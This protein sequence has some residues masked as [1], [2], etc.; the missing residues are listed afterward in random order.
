VKLK[1]N[2]KRNTAFLYETL[3]RELTKTTIQKNEQKK[4]RLLVLIKEHFDRSTLLGKELELYKDLSAGEEI[5][6]YTA[7]K[8]IFEVRRKHAGLDKKQLF[9]EQTTLIDKMNKMFS[10]SIFSN[11]VPNYKNLATINQIFDDNM[12]I[13][14]RV[15]LEENLIS[16]LSKEK[17]TEEKELKPIDNLTYKTFVENYNKEYSET[18]LAEQKELLCKYVSS[19]ADNGLELKMYLNEELGRLKNTIHESLEMNEIKTDPDMNKNTKEVLKLMEN[20][21]DHTIDG[22]M[23]KKVL[24]VQNLVKELETKDNDN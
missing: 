18:L 2:K 14:K 23:V 19:F 11:F 20:F 5:A 13:K 9:K 8:L 21:K 6:P 22:E 1:H 3:I 24:Q 12:S 4:G 17:E 16:K 10:K 15:I 7:E